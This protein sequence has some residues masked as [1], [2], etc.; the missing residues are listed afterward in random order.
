MITDDMLRAA[1][2]K[3]CE[4]YVERRTSNY[5]DTV[6]HNFSPQFEKAI[7]KLKKKADHPFFYHA[8]HRV[9]SIFL[10]VLL[11]ASAW[12]AVD[13]EARAAV[14]GWIKEVYEDLFVYRYDDKTENPIPESNYRPSWLPEGYTE[15]F[16]DDSAELI[17]VVYANEAGEMLK[18]NY[19]QNPNETSWGVDLTQME[20]TPVKVHGNDADLLISTSSEIANCILWSTS[21]NTA[22]YISAFLDA[23]D[24]VRI[25]ESV[26][27]TEN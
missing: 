18:F 17:L 23:D 2:A 19:V 6:Q 11:G 27:K 9:A 14:I 26:E 20:M 25:A 16:V 21:D 5:N 4:L 3:S 7:R 22:F 10:A 1:A 12:L 15:F 8:I 24:L 13:V